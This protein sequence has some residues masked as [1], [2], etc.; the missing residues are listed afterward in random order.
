M[1]WSADVAM[2]ML[3]ACALNVG[4]WTSPGRTY[5]SWRET[6]LMVR[7]LEWRWVPDPAVTSMLP[8]AMA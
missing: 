8:T 3:L 6:A 7:V 2:L 1:M 4:Y 5:W